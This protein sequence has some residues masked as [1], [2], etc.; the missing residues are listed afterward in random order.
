[1]DVR[2]MSGAAECHCVYEMTVALLFLSLICSSTIT[3]DLVS[4][5]VDH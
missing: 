5:C 1:M 4:L 2:C 3:K